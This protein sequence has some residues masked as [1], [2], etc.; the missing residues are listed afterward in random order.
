M[1]TASHSSNAVCKYNNDLFCV[2]IPVSYIYIWGIQSKRPQVKTSPNLHSQ[3]VPRPKRPQAK[4]PN[5]C[6]QIN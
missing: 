6:V 1:W 3:N 2:S 5:S 4:T